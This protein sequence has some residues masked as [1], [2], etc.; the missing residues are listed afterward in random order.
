M[1]QNYLDG[2]KQNNSHQIREFLKYGDW[3]IVE[4]YAKEHDLL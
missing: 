1:T 4:P 3:N 2:G